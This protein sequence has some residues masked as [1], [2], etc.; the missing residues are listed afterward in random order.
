MI[1]QRLVL[2]RLLLARRLHLRL[3][4]AVLRDRLLQDRLQKF[5][6]DAHV[7]RGPV[8]QQLLQMPEPADA[9]AH[10]NHV[11]RTRE[12]R[13]EALRDVRG[14]RELRRDGVVVC[15]REVAV[16]AVHACA[17]EKL[18]GAVKREA[19]DNILKM[20]GDPG[21]ELVE[22]MSARNWPLTHLEI[23][24]MT[25]PETLPDLLNGQGCDGSRLVRPLEGSL[26]LT[27]M[28]VKQLEVR[29]TIP[30]KVRTSHHAVEP[31]RN[32]SVSVAY[33]HGTQN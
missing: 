32:A 6:H 14:A 25:A 15:V 31:E 29:N 3:R 21:G 8:V 13:G 23:D 4:S 19:R 9:R 33:P 24:S 1:Q 27:C 7:L 18:R 30:G 2:L 16:Q 17:E 10:R 11:L 28:P 26:R 5:V 22:Q 12:R 20:V